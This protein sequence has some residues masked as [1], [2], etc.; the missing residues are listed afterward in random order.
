MSF[1]LLVSVLVIVCLTPLIIGSTSVDIKLLT[2]VATGG[3]ITHS[4]LSTQIINER[5]R[6]K[7]FSLNWYLGYLVFGLCVPLATNLPSF[8]PDV[9]SLSAIFL[10]AGLVANN[11]YL[12][13][14]NPLHLATS[15]VLYGM[16]T[17]T[18]AGSQLIIWAGADYTVIQSF[19]VYGCASVFLGIISAIIVKYLAEEIGLHS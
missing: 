2:L 16:G 15:S 17:G 18:I 3:A 14:N 7:K 12:A 19:I 1:N 9:H 4:I 5:R 11:Y 8:N 10:A 13:N 6:P